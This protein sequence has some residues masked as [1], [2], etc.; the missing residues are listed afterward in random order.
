MD[1]LTDLDPNP[2]SGFPQE[3][4]VFGQRHVYC[5]IRKACVSVGTRVGTDCWGSPR[6]LAATIQRPR[7]RNT[8]VGYKCNPSAASFGVLMMCDSWSESTLT[9]REVTVVGGKG[10]RRKR[11]SKLSAGM[12]ESLKPAERVTRAEDAHIKQAASCLL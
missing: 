4:T 8:N 1:C 2:G 12:S 6:R 11:A 9:L 10:R 3:D 7:P 5:V